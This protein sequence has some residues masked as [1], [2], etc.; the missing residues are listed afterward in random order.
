MRNKHIY[1][2]LTI[3]MTVLPLEAASPRTEFDAHLSSVIAKLNRE[4]VNSEGAQ[5]LAALIQSEYGTSVE[6]LRW[7]VDHEFPWG[8]I[9]AFAY[10]QATN[11]RTFAELSSENASGDFWTYTEKAGMSS[12]KMA[13]SLERFSK[14]A[15]RQRNSRI[16][17]QIRNTPALA[18]T[19]DLG[20]GFGLFQEALDFRRIDDLPRPSKVYTGGPL[21]LAKGEK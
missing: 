4:A 11:G 14:R 2:V 13:R 7:A 12:D 20:S 3:L 15:E 9:V 5:L 16:F 17:E 21:E 1:I 6:E 8:Q 19:L 18:R 10:I